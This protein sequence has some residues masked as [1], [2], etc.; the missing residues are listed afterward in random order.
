MFLIK[1]AGANP[2]MWVIIWLVISVAA[3]YTF[4]ISVQSILGVKC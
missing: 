2:I 1:Q 3:I 4:G